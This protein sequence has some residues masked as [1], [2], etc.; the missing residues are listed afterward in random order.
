[1]AEGIP[2]PTVNN[3][4]EPELECSLLPDYPGLLFYSDGRVFRI[5]TGQFLNGRTHNGYKQ[6]GLTPQGQGQ[7]YIH[8]LIARA[9]LP[10]PQNL[11]VINHKNGVR[12]D[13]RAA[14]LEWC[15]NMYNSQGLNT[16]RG[17]GC[18][19]ESTRPKDHK[20]PFKAQYKA[21]GEKLVQK[22]FAT[23]EEAQAFLDAAEEV[24]RANLR[25]DM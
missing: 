24:A 6:L 11:P 7:P 9:F 4:H 15:T 3:L 1:M 23:R 25:P 20:K 12:D 18:I 13:N 19:H 5:K 2:V 16:R 14:N 8:R 10:N 22:V 17:F 21:N